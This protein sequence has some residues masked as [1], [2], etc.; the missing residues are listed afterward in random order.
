MAPNP[1]EMERLIEL[2]GERLER[3]H[4]A[5]CMWLRAKDTQR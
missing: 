4:S 1:R 5:R 3:I 2:F